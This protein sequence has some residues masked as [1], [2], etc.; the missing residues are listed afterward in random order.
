MSVWASRQG[1]SARVRQEARAAR[2]C[3]AH[4]TVLPP[5]FKRRCGYM[6]KHWGRAMVSPRVQERR[7]LAVGRAGGWAVM[8]AQIRAATSGG[9]CLGTAGSGGSRPRAPA[10][11]PVTISSSTTPKLQRRGLSSL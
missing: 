10:N 11:S 8:Q 1:H 7:T 5:L 6:H 4:C 9:H 3:S 2:Q